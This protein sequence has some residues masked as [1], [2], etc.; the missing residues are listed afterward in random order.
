MH[1]FFDSVPWVSL[2]QL[3]QEVLAGIDSHLDAEGALPM[4]AGDEST[5]R[6]AQLCQEQELTQRGSFRAGYPTHIGWRS[7]FK[8]FRQSLKVLEHLGASKPC[9]WSLMRCSVL[10]V[11]KASAAP[12][13]F[14]G[15]S[16]VGDSD[17]RHRAFE[18]EGLGCTP[19]GS[20]NSNNNT[21]LKGSEEFL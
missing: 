14:S 19:R 3:V 5:K 12:W 7:M 15:G 2:R 1:L 17:R 11:C 10:K 16:S 6:N 8:S 18:P 4:S 9:Q 20:G 21:S 13:W